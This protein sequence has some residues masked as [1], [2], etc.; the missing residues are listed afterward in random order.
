MKCQFCLQKV[1]KRDLAVHVTQIH[2]SSEAA[3]KRE[4][5]RRKK[6]L[7]AD[8]GREE[9]FSNSRG[10][11]YFDRSK[12]DFRARARGT[13]ECQKDWPGSSRDV[14]TISFKTSIL[15][16]SQHPAEDPIIANLSSLSFL[17][18]SPHIPSLAIPLVSLASSLGSLSILVCGRCLC[19]VG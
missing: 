13:D 15:I 10:R 11:A 8:R 18:D 17:T 5:E 7:A 1:K 12:A 2:G 4:Q 9:E 6:L 16:F 14:I 3:M 19:A